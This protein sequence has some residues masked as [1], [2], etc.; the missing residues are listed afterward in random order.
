MPRHNAPCPILGAF[1]FLRQGWESTTLSQPLSGRT[2]P[3]YCLRDAAFPATT[4]L[5]TADLRIGTIAP[6]DPGA[7]A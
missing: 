6:A 3:T 2:P 1:L 7:A 5:T 4:G